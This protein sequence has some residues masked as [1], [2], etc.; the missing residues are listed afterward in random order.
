MD[1]DV[2]FAVVLDGKILGISDVSAEGA[3]QDAIATGHGVAMY[4]RINAARLT[5]EPV[6]GVVCV[7]EASEA[8]FSRYEDSYGDDCDGYEVRGGVVD[9]APRTHTHTVTFDD[10]EGCGR[11]YRPQKGFRDGCCGPCSAVIG[12]TYRPW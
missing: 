10:C 9:V 7:V 3:R 6:R 12:L 11:T 2:Y 8:A 5:R 1:P 4:P